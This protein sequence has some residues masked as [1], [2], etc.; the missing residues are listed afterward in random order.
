MCNIP[1]ADWLTP[2]CHSTMLLIAHVSPLPDPPVAIF[3]AWGSPTFR[4]GHSHYQG[5]SGSLGFGATQ[6]LLLSRSLFSTSARPPSPFRPFKTTFVMIYMKLV[7]LLAC[8]P[9]KVPVKI[10]AFSKKSL[11]RALLK[12]WIGWLCTF[13]M[14]LYIL[15]H[16]A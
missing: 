11:L 10:L 1:D 5:R 7:S 2:R 6:V 16:F 13:C 3:T 12:V 9:I 14:L 8:L 4:K 15:D